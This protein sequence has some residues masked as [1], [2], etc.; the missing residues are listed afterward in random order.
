MSFSQHQSPLTLICRFCNVST[1]Q[2]IWQTHFSF[3]IN[4]IVLGLLSGIIWDKIKFKLK[5][6]H[7]YWLILLS[8]VQL[9]D[10]TYSTKLQSHKTHFCKPVI[11]RKG[12]RTVGKKGHHLLLTPFFPCNAHI[13]IYSYIYIVNNIT[14]LPILLYIGLM[15]KYRIQGDLVAR[16]P[17]PP[18]VPPPIPRCQR[19]TKDFKFGYHRLRFVTSNTLVSTPS[20]FNWIGKI[21]AL[22]AARKA[23]LRCPLTWGVMLRHDRTEGWLEMIG[24]VSSD[25]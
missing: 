22:G 2:C 8:L 10:I 11:C 4:Y 6:V 16:C 18:P 7:I 15:L 21:T 25:P 3:V 1:P 5:I 17:P 12:Q 14:I 23:S 19:L 24:A 20:G 13:V 9:D